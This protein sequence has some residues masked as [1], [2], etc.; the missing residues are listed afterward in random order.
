MLQG[1]GSHIRLWC[2]VAVDWTSRHSRVHGQKQWTPAAMAK[3]VARTV[4]YLLCLGG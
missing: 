3:F 2:M 4:E 1:G